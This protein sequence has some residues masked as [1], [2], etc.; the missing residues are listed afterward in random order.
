M[1]VY[2]L[3][4]KF[5]PKN[6]MTFI[7]KYGCFLIIDEL[8][9]T[10]SKKFDITMP[11]HFHPECMLDLTSNGELLIKRGKNMARLVPDH[12]LRWELKRGQEHPYKIGWY[13]PSF[14]I[15]EPAGVFVGQKRVIPDEESSNPRKYLFK[16][17]IFI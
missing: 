16:T 14:Y 17:S 2:L 3:P 7:R 5:I 12:G 11:F 8:I 1:K 6:T 10:G 4:F 9:S 13:S 15:K